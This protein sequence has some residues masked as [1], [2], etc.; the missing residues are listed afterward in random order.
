QRPS[1]VFT[2][3][4]G[5]V[6]QMEPVEDFDPSTDDLAEFTG[7]YSSP[8]AE[9]TYSF[10]VREGSLAR[11]D[12]YGRAIPVRPSGPDAFVGAGGTWVFHS[13]GGRVTSV[14]LVSGRVWD[15]RFERVR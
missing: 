12:R 10:K 11:V 9:V 8:E 15:L 14:S 1:A 5:D 6:F 4:D 7:E 13:E 3:P 2:T